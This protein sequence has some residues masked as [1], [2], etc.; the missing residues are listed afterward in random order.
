MV[1][2]VLV[3]GFGHRSK[4]G[5]DREARD[6][7]QAPPLQGGACGSGGWPPTYEGSSTLRGLRPSQK[8]QENPNFPEPRALRNSC[9]TFCRW[10]L[11][12]VA[13]TSSCP[14]CQRMDR[15]VG[16]ASGS[17]IRSTS[18]QVRRHVV[19]TPVCLAL[20]DTQCR[21]GWNATEPADAPIPARSDAAASAFGG[22]MAQR[23]APGA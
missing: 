12:R 2:T 14:L 18:G 17:L 4:H 9:A 19:T 3:S 22:L 6:S 11:Q 23:P 7:G 1:P 15:N 10:D 21:G 13:S 20:D 5:P 16:S 8:S